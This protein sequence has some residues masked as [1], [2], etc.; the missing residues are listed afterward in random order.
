MTAPDLMDALRG[1]PWPIREALVRLV[2]DEIEA[3]DWWRCA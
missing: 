1:T 3:A 2:I